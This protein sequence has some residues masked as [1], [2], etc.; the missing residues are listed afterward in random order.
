MLEKHNVL[1]SS[2][3]EIEKACQIIS[4]NG[5]LVLMTIVIRRAL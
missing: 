4:S 5:E 1:N 3:D 2:V